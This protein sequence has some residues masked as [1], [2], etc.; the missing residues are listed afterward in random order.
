M[1]VRTSIR[2]VILGQHLPHSN[3]AVRASYNPEVYYAET[4]GKELKCDTCPPNGSE[5]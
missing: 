3:H 1:Q 2:E 5:A 4:L